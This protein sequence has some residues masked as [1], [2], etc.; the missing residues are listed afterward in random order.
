MEN[1]TQY[2]LCIIERWDNT[3][4]ASF[5]KAEDSER[6]KELIEHIGG[7]ILKSYP[8]EGVLSILAILTIDAKESLD[9]GT[10]FSYQLEELI[11]KIYDDAY[12]DSLLN[13]EMKRQA[14]IK[15]TK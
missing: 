3:R 4:Y 9:S 6:E 2:L 5:L 12:S 14:L 7:R 15:N 1:E 13:A 8:I 10:G 11:S